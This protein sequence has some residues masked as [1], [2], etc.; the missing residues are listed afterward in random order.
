MF[1]SAGKEAWEDKESEIQLESR[2]LS[3]PETLTWVKRGWGRASRSMS[4]FNICHKC[5]VEFESVSVNTDTLL[6]EASRLSFGVVKRVRIWVS[7]RNAICLVGFGLFQLIDV[8]RNRGN[9]PEPTILY[10]VTFEWE[11]PLIKLY[12]H[13]VRYYVQRLFCGLWAILPQKPTEY[14]MLRF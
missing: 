8:C 14:G 5:I 10:Q 3:V 9:R 13:F 6:R 11:T 7:C 2:R 1:T 4:K 12:D